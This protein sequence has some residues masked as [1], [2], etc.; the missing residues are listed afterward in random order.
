ME[1]EQK[2][3]PKKE[4]KKAAAPKISNETLN[5]MLES[6]GG[7]DSFVIGFIV[8]G[9]LVSTFLAA[10]ML[11]FF[12]SESAFG[13]DF[14]TLGPLAIAGVVLIAYLP[15]FMKGIKRIRKNDDMTK[16]Y[17][18]GDYKKAYE[19]LNS[20][21][22]KNESALRQLVLLSFYKL[23]KPEETKAHIADLYKLTKELDSE[24]NEVA[25]KL[26]V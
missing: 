11:L 22:R 14:L 13:I 17:E 26:N 16:F 7:V 1:K 19:I 20:L 10:A 24:I 5:L 4:V 6:K 25:V 8:Q 18:V 2:A 21:N 12:K 15:S 23:N 9:F 3:K